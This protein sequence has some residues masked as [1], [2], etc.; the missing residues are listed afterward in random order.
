MQLVFLMDPLDSIDESKDTS[1]AFMVAAHERGH[2]LLH[3]ELADVEIVQSKVVFHGRKV[4]PKPGASPPWQAGDLEE[5]E[6]DKI[7]AV[8]VRKDPPFDK[9]YLEMTWFL[10]LLPDRV[11]VVNSP[12]GLRAINEK[13]WV[14]RFAAL[15]TETFVTNKM[16]RFQEELQRLGKVIVKPVDGHGGR[17]VFLVD[18]NDSNSSVIF[19]T[20]SRGGEDHVIIQRFIP[21]ANE[22]DKRVL[23][24]EGE[25]LGAVLR[26]HRDGEHRNNFFAGGKAQMAEI[27]PREMESIQLL[28]KELLQHE[29]FF[30]G[31]DFLGEVLIE[32]NVTSPTCLQEMNRLM[33]QRLDLKVIQA[34]ESKVEKRRP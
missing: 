3:V 28:K 18:K 25:P 6:A 32:V 19:E 1:Y 7:D 16:I 8:M 4:I 21:E 31:L 14:N 10:D 22:G 20:L 15:T 30:V 5:S 17:G 13:I 9:T 2:Q 12:S 27:T 26:V 33:S 24:L 11:V 34:L 29:M 23:L